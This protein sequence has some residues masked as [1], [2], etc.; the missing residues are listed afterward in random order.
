[1]AGIQTHGFDAV[2]QL[3][4]TVL[5]NIISGYFDQDNFFCREV[6]EPA[7][8]DAAIPLINSCQ[9]F[10]QDLSLN[11]P[12]GTDTPL[13]ASDQVLDF[14]VE[15]QDA[16]GVL[17]NIRAVVGLNVQRILPSVGGSLQT[18]DWIVIDF[19]NNL[20]HFEALGFQNPNPL[21]NLSD[22]LK[23]N[24]QTVTIPILPFPVFANTNNPEEIGETMLKVIDSNTSNP[25]NDA[26]GIM[27]NYG[28]NQGNGD[29][30][31][32]TERFLD[33]DGNPST[34]EQSEL[35]ISFA[36]I[37]RLISPGIEQSIGLPPGSF[38]DCNFNGSVNVGDD[39]DLTRISMEPENGH[40]AVSISV[41][42]DTT[43]VDASANV[44]ARIFLDVSGGELIIRYEIDEPD[45][46]T[47]VEWYCYLVAAVVGAI[48]GAATGGI[49]AAVAGAAVGGAIVGGAIGG[50][51]IGIVLVALIEH[52]A[53]T[54]FK[55]VVQRVSDQLGNALGAQAGVDILPLDINLADAFIDDVTLQYAMHPREYAEIKAQ[56]TIQLSSGQFLDLDN[57]TVKNENFLGADLR[58]NG[59]QN[60]RSIEQL[61][62]TSI[63]AL[64]GR[65]FSSIRRYDLYGLQYGNISNIPL[66]SIAYH[67]GLPGWL[68]GG[69]RPN[70]RLFAARTS[71]GC[72]SVFQVY[73]VT[74][75]RFYIRYRTYAPERA[76]NNVRILGGFS[77]S[78]ISIDPELIDVQIDEPVYLPASH[79]YKPLKGKKSLNLEHIRGQLL[80]LCGKTE[81]HPDTLNKVLPE[82][83]PLQLPANFRPVGKWFQRVQT[84]YKKAYGTFK[85]VANLPSST[86]ALT[87]WTVEGTTLQQDGEG[88][89]TIK[90]IKFAYRVKMN[91]LTLSSKSSKSF[92]FLIKVAVTDK[93]GTTLIAQRCVDYKNRCMVEIEVPPLF[94]DYLVKFK[95][96]YGLIEIPIQ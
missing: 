4:P 28:G 63:A 8:E 6:V 91:Y 33:E 96:E 10:I 52:I 31:S 12:T 88:N 2:F 24:L 34:S 92:Q 30:A 60:N 71:D 25:L 7:F 11:R 9:A 42:K 55:L 29:L 26:L 13:M 72:W 93:N 35:G 62:G 44:N 56:G 75:S 36:W 41:Q 54:A 85:A 45:V 59:Q 80:E 64:G 69:Y 79:F 94:K 84:I 48:L 68:G 17:G 57:G 14:N 32:F 66:N 39:T 65:N 89:L 27:L 73:R 81:P 38:S 40:I 23:D 70:F 90:G 22:L 1:M 53:D 76:L 43:C 86:I 51:I 77:C 20:K 5:K 82:L 46:E 37:C 87:V 83:P 16:S 19:E 78:P 95:E 47:D 67:S 58:L 21:I 50:G 18:A 49:G 74:N 61:C 15:I 3:S